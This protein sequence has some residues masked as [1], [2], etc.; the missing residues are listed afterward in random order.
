MLCRA[1]KELIERDKQLEHHAH[2]RVTKHAEELRSQI[3]S[4]QRERVE[5][6]NNFFAEGLKIDEEARLRR[7]KVEQAKE[8]KLKELRELGIPDKYLSEVERKA[9][10]STNRLVA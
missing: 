7:Q 6:R 3:M 2:S 1:Q 10:A 4:K 8:K 5:A 9:H